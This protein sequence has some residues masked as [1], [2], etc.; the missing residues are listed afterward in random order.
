M[1]DIITIWKRTFFWVSEND[2]IVKIRSLKKL[3]KNRRQLLCMRD[4]CEGDESCLG[5]EV[6]LFPVH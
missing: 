5:V 1:I 3:E 6:E 2:Y 4:E